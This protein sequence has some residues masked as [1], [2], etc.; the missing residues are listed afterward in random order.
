MRQA[1]VSVELALSTALLASAA[2]L[3]HSFVNVTRADRGYEVK[4]VLTLELSPGGQ[5]YATGPQRTA[6]YQGLLTEIQAL[7]DVLAVGAVDS[8]PALGESGT[9]AIFFSTDT[10][11]PGLALQRP[12]AGLRNATPGYFTASGTALRAGRAFTEQDV[13]PVAVIHDDRT[14]GFGRDLALMTE[15]QSD[16]GRD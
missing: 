5:R 13:T 2:L 3:L 15:R 6:F 1:L 4:H 10:D 14:S 9:Q 16:C 12:V 8:M 7:P 11:S